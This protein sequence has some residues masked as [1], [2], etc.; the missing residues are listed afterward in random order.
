VKLY[1]KKKQE[2]KIPFGVDKDLGGDNEENTNWM[3]RCKK[4]VKINP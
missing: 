3:E 1:I 4:G 2:D